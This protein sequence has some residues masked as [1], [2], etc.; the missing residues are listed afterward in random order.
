MYPVDVQDST[1]DA[2]CVH[3]FPAHRL[4]YAGEIAGHL[5]RGTNE[6]LLHRA[7]PAPIFRPS[8]TKLLLRQRASEKTTFPGHVD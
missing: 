7:P 3:R 2:L 5:M 8:D 6:G 4:L 1:V